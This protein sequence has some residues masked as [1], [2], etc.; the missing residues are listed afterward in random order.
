MSQGFVTAEESAE[1]FLENEMS[2]WKDIAK[3]FGGA[4]EIWATRSPGRMMCE[5]IVQLRA[6]LAASQDQVARLRGA[7]KQYEDDDACEADNERHPDSCRY[8]NTMAA[9]HHTPEPRMLTELKAAREA[10]EFYTDIANWNPSASDETLGKITEAD[11][12][13]VYDGITAGGLKACEAFDRINKF[14]KEFE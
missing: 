6:Q 10:L 5:E 13:K 12:I 3:E 2:D 14:L 9:L 7:L 4:H 8:C 1:Q 11:M